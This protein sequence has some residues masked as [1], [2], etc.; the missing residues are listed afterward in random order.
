IEVIARLRNIRSTFNI[1]PSIPLQAQIAP[2]DAA[3]RDL[4]ARTEDHVKRLARIEELQIV[5][6][7]P[8]R[9]GSARAVV[10][11]SEIAVPLEGLIDFDKERSRLE[12]ELNKLINERGGLEKRLS[13]QD[14]IS[15]AAPEVVETTRARAEE[16]DD[17]VAKLR[18]VIEA[19]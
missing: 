10:G 7:L 18:A 16:L 4:I 8:S 15:R 12:K 5:D 6:K 13:N 9:K 14:F 2:A 19:L 1:A 17:Q 3:T 11:A